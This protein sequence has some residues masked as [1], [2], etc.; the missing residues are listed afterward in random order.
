MWKTKETHDPGLYKESGEIEKKT[1]WLDKLLNKQRNVQ[2]EGQDQAQDRAEGRLTLEGDVH[3]ALI[4]MCS[5]RQGA[6][7]TI[8]MLESKRNPG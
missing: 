4:Q 5:L 6:P 2:S 1:A 7:R 8:N 3:P